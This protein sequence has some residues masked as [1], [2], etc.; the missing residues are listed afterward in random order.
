MKGYTWALVV[1]I[2]DSN[3][4]ISTEK[5][6]FRSVYMDDVIR[7]ANTWCDENSIWAEDVNDKRLSDSK[8][9][10]VALRIEYKKES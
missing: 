1:Q 3:G 6:V 2:T 5:V 9:P 4:A 7:A 8:P 10:M